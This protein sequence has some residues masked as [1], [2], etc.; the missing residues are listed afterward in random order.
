M[1]S[2]TNHILAGKEPWPMRIEQSYILTNHSFHRW[3]ADEVSLRSLF[4]DIVKSYF[5]RR[6]STLCFVQCLCS[7]VKKIIIQRPEVLFWVCFTIWVFER[8]WKKGV[9]I[10]GTLCLHDNRWNPQC[11]IWSFSF[12]NRAA[13]TVEGDFFFKQ[14]LYIR[15]MKL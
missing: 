2:L 7:Q 5:P 1:N 6:N 3:M 13:P 14:C 4:S 10:S 11:A 12:H 15:A 9:L 8:I